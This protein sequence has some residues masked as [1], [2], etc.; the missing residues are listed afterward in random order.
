[1]I[2]K[3][4]ECETSFLVP[5][6]SLAPKGRKVRCSNCHT[7][8]FQKYNPEEEE[9]EVE[10]ED[11]Q[12]VSE[13][14][15]QEEGEDK[16]SDNLGE[17]TQFSMSEGD[18]IQDQS[19]GERGEDQSGGNDDIPKGVRP[20]SEIEE[21]LDIPPEEEVPQTTRKG[22]SYGMAASVMIFILIG[23]SLSGEFVSRYWSASTIFYNSLGY[24]FSI[25]GQ[26]LVFDRV[27]A[28]VVPQE[29][30]KGQYAKSRKLVVSGQIINLVD[31]PRQVAP[32]KI[33]VL[34]GTSEDLKTFTFKPDSSRIEG[35][36]VLQFQQEFKHQI[37]PKAKSLKIYFTPKS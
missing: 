3:C 17:D 9:D 13:R 7:E 31:S 16:A 14:E 2:I 12:T 22:V 36:A 24:D 19:S 20:E 35:E 11:G 33:E 4:P 28:R 23:F 34:S 32:V 8:W 1:M 15:E 26:N 5:A 21:D 10:T 29:A 6:E 25:P 37:S 30:E 27:E 18:D